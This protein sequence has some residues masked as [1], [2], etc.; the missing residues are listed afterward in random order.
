MRGVYKLDGFPHGGG[1]AAAAI[2]ES[3]Q[4]LHLS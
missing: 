2:E 4:S 3:G 1:G